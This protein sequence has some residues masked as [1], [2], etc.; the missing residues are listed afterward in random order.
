MTVT[1]SR[2]NRGM[3]LLLVSF[4]FLGYEFHR[5]QEANSRSGRRVVAASVSQQLV[6]AW[7]VVSLDSRP[8]GDSAWKP[9]YGP[10]PSGY[11]QYDADGRM[12]VQFCNDP[13]TKKFASGDDLQPS[14]EEAKTAYLNYVAYFGTYTVDETKHVVTHHVKGSLLPSYNASE[15]LRPFRIEGDVLTIGGKDP[16]GSEWRRVFRRVKN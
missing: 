8:N 12:S 3:I 13:P 1:N 9:D 14:G 2:K 4:I 5:L 15:Q 16:D 6:G 7:E 10:H 11:I